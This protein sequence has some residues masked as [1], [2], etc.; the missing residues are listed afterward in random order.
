MTGS[1]ETEKYPERLSYE[2]TQRGLNR[3]ILEGMASQTMESLTKGVFLVGLALQLGASNFVV[4]LLGAVP[5]LSNLFQIPAILLVEKYRDRRNIVAICSFIGRSFLLI[6][7]LATLI[8]NKQLA[9]T[10]VILAIAVRYCFGA[11]A[12]CA[13]N[14]WMRDLVPKII[15]GQFF[16]RRMAITTSIAS[17]LG[18]G[19]GFFL[20]WW[21]NIHPDIVVQGYSALYVLGF[22]AAMI[23][24]SLILTIPHPR[25]R[26]PEVKIYS[27][28][29]SFRHMIKEPLKNENFRKL[30]FFLMSWNFAINLA[31]PFFTV[32]MLKTLKYDMIFVVAIT[33]MSQMVNVLSLKMWGNKTDKY[34]N[35]TVLGIC[36]TLFV[37]CIFGWTFATYPDERVYTTSLLVILHILMGIALS[38][39]SLSTANIAMK[40][41]PSAKATSYLAINTVMTSLAAGI[42]PL[43]G[44]LFA[45]YFEDKT[46]SMDFHWHG[47]AQDIFIST[48][49]IKE[50]GFFFLLA[51][52]LGLYSLRRLALVKEDG[53]VNEHVVIREIMMDTGRVLKSLST[54]D[55]LR[56]L[57]TAPMAMMV[58]LVKRK[59]K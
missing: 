8:P 21:R 47:T 54:V 35:K 10:I 25:L 22:I 4:G 13:W 23:S 14:S 30:I 50:W 58:N 5:F 28:K 52:V 29:F 53:E 42:A 15:L 32:Y 17:V 46:L 26:E 2:E 16:S 48:M 31:S 37:F 40:L 43:F 36:G 27:G 20:D 57:T 38:G 55:G 49:N 45:D 59:G 7:A 6:V 33:L 34:S 39:V 56:D 1:K 11:L 9:L 19:A 44:G 18:L 3:V 41:T 51:F 24:S 12:N